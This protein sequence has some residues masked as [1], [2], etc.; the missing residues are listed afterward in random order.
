M[1]SKS[2]ENVGDIDIKIFTVSPL[3]KIKCIFGC[4]V[5]AGLPAEQVEELDRIERGRA[6]AEIKI[7]GMIMLGCLCILSSLFCG[8]AL[9]EC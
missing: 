6:R 3:E 1:I 9:F 7:N 5:F 8:G 2:E 4:I